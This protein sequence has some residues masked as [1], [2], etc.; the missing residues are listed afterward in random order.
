M[1]FYP[2]SAIAYWRHQVPMSD[3]RMC[4]RAIPRLRAE[5][6]LIEATST[7][8]GSGVLKKGAAKATIERWT[9]EANGG[10]R[11]RRAARRDGKP[12]NL[13]AVGIAVVP[14]VKQ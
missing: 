11:V 2:G 12:R 8:V 7:A 13:S 5:E 1:R 9:R 3:I 14:R 10:R 4:L 6:S